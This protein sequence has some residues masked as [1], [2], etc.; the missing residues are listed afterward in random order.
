MRTQA[1]QNA[2]LC[3][4]MFTDVSEETTAFVWMDQAGLLN[5]KVVS[6]FKTSEITNQNASP[7]AQRL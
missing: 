4:W 1:L 3:L 7:P 2:T 6:S 5:M